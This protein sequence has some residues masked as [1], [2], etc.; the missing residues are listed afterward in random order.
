[1]RGV[2]FLLL[3]RTTATKFQINRKDGPHRMLTE[4]RHRHH[5]VAPIARQRFASK[6][7]EGGISDQTLN[8][9]LIVA[10]SGTF[11]AIMDEVMRQEPAKQL[12]PLARTIHCPAGDCEAICREGG[13]IF[14]T[15]H[16][17]LS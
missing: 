16:R 14:A 3:I 17:S 10:L 4:L 6:P 13:R 9:A 7:R 12:G 8:S 11:I 1:M 15:K 5:E 2:D